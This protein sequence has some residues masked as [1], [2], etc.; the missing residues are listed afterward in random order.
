MG[1]F[2]K[3]RYPSVLMNLD[4]RDGLDVEAESWLNPVSKWSGSPTHLLLEVAFILE[5]TFMAV[6]EPD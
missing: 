5:V 4:F 3:N 1:I 2:G 6:G